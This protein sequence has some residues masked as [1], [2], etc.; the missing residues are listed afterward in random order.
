MTDTEPKSKFESPYKGQKLFDAAIQ[1]LI[2]EA[3]QN[4]IRGIRPRQG[5]LQ[6]TAQHL[7]SKLCNELRKRNITGFDSVDEFER[8]LVESV[9]IDR[10]EYDQ[11][12]EFR[13]LHDGPT[14]G[15]VSGRGKNTSRSN[16]RRRTKT[17]RPGNPSAENVVSDVQS[18]GGKESGTVTEQSKDGQEGSQV[19]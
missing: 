4:L 13:R 3:D 11:F 5:T 14:G 8:F 9:L 17:P 7:W 18:G 12:L 10:D 2:G 19:G 1:I 15:T 6:T 16:D